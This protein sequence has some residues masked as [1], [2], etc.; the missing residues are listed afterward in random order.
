[1]N[2]ILLDQFLC[3]EVNIEIKS[4]EQA[5]YLYNL[6]AESIPGSCDDIEPWSENDYIN[7]SFVMIE[8]FP[9]SKY[10]NG[11]KFSRSNKSVIQYDEL[12][13]D[14]SNELD[15]PNIDLEDVL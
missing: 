9:G 3:G 2:Q 5:N 10:F 8:G 1:M 12:M 6:A 7:Y 4:N 13:V 11:C 15:T 14:E